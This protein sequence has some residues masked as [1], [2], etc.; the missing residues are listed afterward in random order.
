MPL[1]ENPH[2][3]DLAELP[4]QGLSADYV[5]CETRRALA[6][7]SSPSAAATADRATR[8]WPGIDIDV[9]TGPHEKKTEPQDVREAVRAAFHGGAD[10]V[11][12]PR[13][14]SERCLANLRAAG[15]ALRG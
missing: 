14:Y 9:P 6:G 12:L 13:K 2:T 3:C 11:I 4:P 1:S 10:G 15:E 5:E 7:V 8:I